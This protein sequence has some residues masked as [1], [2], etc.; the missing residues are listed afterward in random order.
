MNAIFIVGKGR[1]SDLFNNFYEA[2]YKVTEQ[3][4]PTDKDKK[5]YKLLNSQGVSYV[6]SFYTTCE[7]RCESIKS[8]LAWDVIKRNQSICLLKM[9]EAFKD[10]YQMSVLTIDKINE[11]SIEMYKKFFVNN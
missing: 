8:E 3:Q 11:E 10:D 4:N 6:R 2:I 1:Y 9:F 7:E 5:I